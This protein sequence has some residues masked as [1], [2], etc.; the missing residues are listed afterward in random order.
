MRRLLAFGA[1]HDAAAHGLVSFLLLSVSS[2]VALAAKVVV[3]LGFA[4]V[5]ALPAVVVAVFATVVSVPPARW[6][7]LAA[8]VLGGAVAMALLD[9]TL[10]NALPQAEVAVAN[11]L[12]LPMGFVGG[13]FIPLESLPGW[14]QTAGLAT[15]MRPW[16]E[17]SLGA[18]YGA[19]PS[20]AGWAALAGWIVVLGSLATW[21]YRRDQ[22]QRFR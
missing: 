20:A 14:A 7:L 18:A 5:G 13:I 10:D 17:V 11:V 6:P 8:A 22:T 4:V 2:R 9:L 21:A 3:G 1:I 15:P 12:F 19:S 16:V